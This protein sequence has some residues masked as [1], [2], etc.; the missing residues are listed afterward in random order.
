MKRIIIDTNFIME[1]SRN[2]IDLKKEADR[3]MDSKYEILKVEGTDE[4]LEKIIKEQKGKEAQTA[5]LGMAMTKN[6][7]TVRAE[8]SNVDEKIEKL[9]GK[10]T[11]IATHDKELKKKL[12]KPVIIIRQKKYLQL[13]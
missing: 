5:R 3:L 12:I 2:R 13:I 8:G 9:Q 1:I 10:D 4:E 11:I 6:I 7:K